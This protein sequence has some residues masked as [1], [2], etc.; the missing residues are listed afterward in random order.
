MSRGGVLVWLFLLAAGPGLGEVTLSLGERDGQPIY[1][2]ENE[3]LRSEIAHTRGRSPLSYFDKISGVEQLRQLEPLDRN[4]GRH[5]SHGGVA[6]CV[7]WTG[8]S[9]YMGY[10]WTQ[11]WEMTARTHDRRAELVGEVTFPYADPVTGRLCELRFEKRM[12]A[13]EGSTRLKMDYRIENVGERRARFQHCVHGSPCVGGECDEGDYFYAPGARCWVAWSG[14]LPQYEIPDESWF[15]WPIPEAIDF[16]PG[17]EGGLQLFVPASWGVVGDDK[18]REVMAMVSSPVLAGGEEIPVY[19]GYTR[20]EKTYYLEPSITRH[21]SNQAERWEREGYSVDLERGEACVYTVDMA[22]FHG[23]SKEQVRSV[24]ALTG[25]YVLLEEPRLGSGDGAAAV[26]IVLGVS[27]D[28]RVILRQ[29]AGGPAL[30]ERDLRPGEVA[31]ISEKVP[32][33]EGVGELVLVLQNAA[34]EQVLARG[35]GE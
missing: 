18:T 5:Y 12:T 30:L 8:G 29:A 6:E 22:M 20:G 23:I 28:A 32:L 33:P 9:P 15:K 25:D 27:G 1:V 34:G 21:I 13:Y 10:L 2:F 3:Y 16:R 24:H 4:H 11:P 26:E 35:D 14:L 31:R 17:G 7:P 19:M